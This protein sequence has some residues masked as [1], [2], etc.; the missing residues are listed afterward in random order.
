[1]SFCATTA[2]LRIFYRHVMAF[3][4]GV[5]GYKMV[6]ASVLRAYNTGLLA[7]TSF[8]PNSGPNFLSI[9]FCWRVEVLLSGCISPNH[10][11][12]MVFI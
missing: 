3:G 12:G 2:F 9:C 4:L 6:K 10:S 7:G 5:I 11:L 8:R 1:M